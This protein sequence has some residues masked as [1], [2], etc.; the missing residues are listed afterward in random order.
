VLY[1]RPYSFLSVS[2]VGEINDDWLVAWIMT[3][4]DARAVD[5][6]SLTI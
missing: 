2:G 5:Y 3:D 6:L 1:H 4:I